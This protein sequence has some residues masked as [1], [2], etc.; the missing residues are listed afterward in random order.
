MGGGAALYCAPSS[1]GPPRD[2]DDGIWAT[3]PRRSRYT[4]C[5]VD[6]RAA[7]GLGITTG[8]ASLRSLQ[9]ASGHPARGKKKAPAAN[10]ADRFTVLL[11][12][13]Q[14]W[15]RFRDHQSR[16]AYGVEDG[17]IANATR[18]STDCP[19]PVNDRGPSHPS[20]VRSPDRFPNGRSEG[21]KNVLAATTGPE[22]SV[23]PPR[24]SRRAYCIR[25]LHS[26]Q[27][28]RP[29][30][31]GK[32][33]QMIRRHPWH[34]HGVPHSTEYLPY[35][36][37]YLLPSRPIRLMHHPPDAIVRSI[38]RGRSAKPKIAE[39][40]PSGES[41]PGDPHPTSPHTV[42][43]IFQLVG[44]PSLAPT[45][46]SRYRCDVARPTIFIET[47]SRPRPGV[48][49]CPPT[50]RVLLRSLTSQVSRQGS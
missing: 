17:A 39:H 11:R 42:I 2:K 41:G 16:L 10:E 33:P 45:A 23:R 21:F 28:A 35:G 49:P 43:S 14:P 13:M 34:R 24:A 9:T 22:R 50:R 44:V 4:V 36:L 31:T 3:S 47:S 15:N 12:W 1:A 37:Q 8:S 48:W 18:H 32:L 46:L 5:T 38:F 19:R 30:D 40:V 6:P 25:P 29:E 7:G 27:E 20:S 26:T